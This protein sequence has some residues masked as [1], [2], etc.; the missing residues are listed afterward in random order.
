MELMRCIWRL[1][2]VIVTSLAVAEA[3]VAQVMILEDEP[4]STLPAAKP[5]LPGKSYHLISKDTCCN[6][7]YAVAWPKGG[8][9][10]SCPRAENPELHCRLTGVA[11]IA[12]KYSTKVHNVTT[13]AL[14]NMQYIT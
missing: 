9:G 13:A 5:V 10:G 12:I 14:N 1:V 3:G 2:Y 6:G 4:L 8:S 11:G 7:S